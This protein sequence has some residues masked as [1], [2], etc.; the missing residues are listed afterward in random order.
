MTS[1]CW[2]ESVGG[3]GAALGARIG[4]LGIKVMEYWFEGS[5]PGTWTGGGGKGKQV[6][7]LFPD[8]GVVYSTGW[9]G[10]RSELLGGGQWIG[11]IFCL[12]KRM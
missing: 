6:G 8:G 1:S 3:V 10:L 12:E 4:G 5:R 7:Y 11:V 9:R 2:L